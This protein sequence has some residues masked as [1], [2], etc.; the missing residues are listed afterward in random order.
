ML[1]LHWV[2]RILRILHRRIVRI[3]RLAACNQLSTLRVHKRASTVCWWSSSSR[4][5]RRIGSGHGAVRIH[6][7]IIWWRRSSVLL[8]RAYV[9]C[10]GLQNL[11]DSRIKLEALLHQFRGSTPAHLLHKLQLIQ[12]LP[13]RHLCILRNRSRGI[14]HE[15]VF[16]RCLGG[17]RHDSQNRPKVTSLRSQ[18]L[19]VHMDV[20]PKTNVQRA[21]GHSVAIL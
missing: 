16:M 15:S 17:M 4:S 3:L 7:S 18:L 5:R 2:I 9:H 20:V 1:S 8:S 12:L 14:L 11:A 6:R 19:N 10:I 21:G 13:Q